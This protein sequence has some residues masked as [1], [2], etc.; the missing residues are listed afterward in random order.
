MTDRQYF[1]LQYRLK[2]GKLKEQHMVDNLNSLIDTFDNKEYFTDH[3]HFAYLL[4]TTFH[5][6]TWKNSV[7]K[8]IKE[9]GRGR[10]RPYGRP[11]PITG[12]TYYGRGYVQITWK[13]NYYTMSKV[14]GLDLINQPDLTL[15]PEV[16]TKIIFYGMKHGSFTGR[17]LSHYINDK[18]C[19]YRN[20]RRIINGTDRASTIASY[21]RKFE[22]CIRELPQAIAID[23]TDNESPNSHKATKKS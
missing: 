18:K 22:Q 23:G 15:E 21:A 20:A 14:T 9:G 6:S 3:R 11:D 7:W 13:A 10:G 1:F 16:A 2:F 4:A 12:Q 8:P 17:K 19:D 5:E